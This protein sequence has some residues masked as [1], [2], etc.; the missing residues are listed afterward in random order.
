MPW[1]STGAGTLQFR[2]WPDQWLVFHPLSGATHLLSEAA[3]VVL[4]ALDR[5]GSALDADALLQLL[6]G[7]DEIPDDDER[8]TVQAALDS[9]VELGLADEVSA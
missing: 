1:Q 8:S 2:R 9:F 3:G 5:H 4:E 7:S 6:M